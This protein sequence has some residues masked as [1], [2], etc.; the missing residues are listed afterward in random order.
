MY[1][2]KAVHLIL[3]LLFLQKFPL[4]L[5]KRRFNTL[6]PFILSIPISLFV[7]QRKA[8]FQDLVIKSCFKTIIYLIGSFFERSTVQIDKPDYHQQTA[9]NQ[10]DNRK[11]FKRILLAHLPL[12]FAL[13]SS[14]KR[15]FCHVQQMLPRGFYICPPALRYLTTY[16]TYRQP[17]LL[18]QHIKSRPLLLNIITLFKYGIHLPGPT[19]HQK[20]NQE[21]RRKE[22]KDY[23]L[24]KRY[25]RRK[26]DSFNGLSFLLIQPGFLAQLHKSV[27]I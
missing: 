19:V 22:Q 24:D 3:R 7:E 2:S 6:F 16:L 5:C 13:L 25:K 15:M 21:K 10:P 14:R 17:H 26:H 8:A 18:C 9:G 12:P 20:N 11:D 1:H 23:I 27:A 4:L